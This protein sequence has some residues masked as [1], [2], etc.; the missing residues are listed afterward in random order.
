VCW[1][2]SRGGTC[3]HAPVLRDGRILLWREAARRLLLNTAV[4]EL[5]LNVYVVFSITVSRTSTKAGGGR[6][7]PDPLVRDAKD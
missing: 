6:R 2:R 1:S 5:L 7:R 4:A 3:T